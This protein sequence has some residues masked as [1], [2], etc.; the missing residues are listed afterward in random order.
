VLEQGRQVEE[1]VKA[2]ETATRDLE[3]AQ[4]GLG[5]M[6][7]ESVAEDGHVVVCF[8]SGWRRSFQISPEIV[9]YYR[10]LVPSRPPRRRAPWADAG[11][12]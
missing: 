2:N 11:E 4:W 12:S 5:D 7:V 6:F 10:R 3:P 9:P 1:M 8:P